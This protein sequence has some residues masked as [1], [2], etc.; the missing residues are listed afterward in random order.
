MPDNK[1]GKLR[2]IG[3]Q[4]RSRVLPVIEQQ[5]LRP[6]PDRVRETLFNWLQAEIPGARCLDLFTGSGALGFEAASRGAKK[7]LML[8][9]QG[10][11]CEVL[12]NNI[13]LLAADNIELHQQDAMTWLATPS[14]SFDLV[15][16][17]PPYATDLL[18]KSCWLLEQNQHL[19]DEAY[20]YLECP[21]NQDLPDLPQNWQIIRG[22]KAGQVGYYL[23]LRNKQ[24]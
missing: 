5:G 19:A 16:V 12:K 18:A 8:E 11:A 17:D 24:D 6:T 13:R 1:V 20:I 22:K 2:I 4:W 14:E 3:G 21:S 9:K 15:F 7:V 10:A 23:A